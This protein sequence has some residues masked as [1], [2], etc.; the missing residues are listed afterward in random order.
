MLADGLFVIGA[1]ATLAD[2][3]SSVIPTPSMIP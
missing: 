2:C 1:A 3:N